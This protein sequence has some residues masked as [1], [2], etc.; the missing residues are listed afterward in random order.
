MRRNFS[1]HTDGNAACPVQKHE[2]KLGGQLYGLLKRAV[3]VGNKVNV[4][5][6]EFREHQLRDFR[7]A[8][9]R[10]THCRRT[11]AITRA[12]VALAV[13]K[14]ITKTEILSHAHHGVVCGLVSMRMIFAKNV[15]HHTR[16][17][18][19]LGGRIQTHAVHC[20]ENAALHGFHAVENVGQSAALHNGKRV[21]EISACGV[22]G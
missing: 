1:G 2:R 18:D 20:I 22:T 11:V 16:T 21:L 6:I 19:G 10:I 7:E 4:F 14:R 17:L 12:E 5:G 9:F 15:T 3:V 13:H 8:R